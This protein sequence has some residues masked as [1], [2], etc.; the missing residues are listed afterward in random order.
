M[1]IVNPNAS[2]DWQGT[3][4]IGGQAAFS[5]LLTNDFVFMG[6]RFLERLGGES[7]PATDSPE[8]YRTQALLLQKR[9]AGDA[10]VIIRSIRIRY[11]GKV[12]E[13]P[14][15]AYKVEF[16]LN[17][18]NAPEKTVNFKIVDE[19][20]EIG[21]LPTA[22]RPVHDFLGWFMED[23]CVTPLEETTIFAQG[24]TVYAK[25]EALPVATLQYDYNFVGAPTNPADALVTAD[26]AIG[27]SALPAVP[28][29]LD[30]E[31]VGWFDA[32]TGGTQVTATST[33]TLGSVTKLYAQWEAVNYPATF[34]EKIQT[35]VTSVPVH[36]FYLPAGKTL[37]DYDRLIVKIKVDIADNASISGRLRAWGDY[38]VWGP[39]VTNRPGMGNAAGDRLLTN[40]GLDS[41]S[42]SS[43]DGAADGGWVEYELPLNA[44]AACG[45]SNK[46]NGSVVTIGW[47]VIPPGGGSGNRVYSF[48]DLVLSNEDKDDQIPA[49]YPLHHALWGSTGLGAY[50]TQN[51]T[52][53]PTRVLLSD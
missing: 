47:G 29:R 5:T 22:T 25:W 26:A 52:D 15:P 42:Q 40:P 6:N 33:F 20:G 34:G 32:A 44:I 12:S 19:N 50:V 53:V 28:L 46:G 24:G 45:M 35:T 37:A 31:F 38:G 14:P 30:N 11:D 13:A 48:K 4:A 43:T 21:K 9:S 16:D 10:E 51:G 39:A 36:G 18:P 17:Y 49:L 3:N 27:A 7:N 41:F 23:T 8:N 1:F 2:T